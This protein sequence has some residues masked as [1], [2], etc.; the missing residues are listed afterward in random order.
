MIFARDSCKRFSLIII[1]L[2]SIANV[3]HNIVN[4]MPFISMAHLFIPYFTWISA[5]PVHFIEKIR[6]K[7]ILQINHLEKGGERQLQASGILQQVS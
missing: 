4:S 2:H 1:P 3:K 5:A 6:H 7:R